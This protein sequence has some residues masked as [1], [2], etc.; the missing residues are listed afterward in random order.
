MKFLPNGM[1]DAF[2]YGVGG[3]S[4]AICWGWPMKLKNMFSTH[5][6]VIGLAAACLLAGTARAQEIDNTVFWPDS[7]NVEVFP[8]PA[9]MAVVNKS[10]KVATYPAHTEPESAIGQP[11]VSQETVVSRGTARE[12]WLIGMSILLMSPA[13]SLGAVQGATCKIQYECTRLPRQEEHCSLLVFQK[14]RVV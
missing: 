8:P 14:A 13:A 4:K 1:T 6:V 7:A 5:A 12:G 9:H 2:V 3:L 10:N 11:T